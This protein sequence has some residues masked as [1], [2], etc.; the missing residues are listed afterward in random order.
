MR[1]PLPPGGVWL[2]E[3]ENFLV[4]GDHDYVFV[5]KSSTEQWNLGWMY[6]N[7]VAALVTWDERYA[8]VVGCGVMICDLLRFGEKVSE[9]ESWDETPVVHLMADPKD[10]WWFSAVEQIARDE[11]SIEVR[12]A[13]DLT[14]AHVGIYNLPRIGVDFR[15]FHDDIPRSIYFRLWARTPSATFSLRPVSVLTCPQRSPAP[16][17]TE[18]VDSIIFLAAAY[19]SFQRGFSF[20]ACRG[21][22]GSLP[23]SCHSSLLITHHASPITYA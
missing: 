2:A 20:V 3:S 10:L 1:I 13:T 16:T 11:E 21:N 22:W 18:K 23:M 7:A 8:I 14:D 9:G 12:I 17:S 15:D 19:S 6:G 5:A 4:Y